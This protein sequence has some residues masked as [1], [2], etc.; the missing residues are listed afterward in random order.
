MVLWVGSGTARMGSRMA[1]ETEQDRSAR[2]RALEDTYIE[3]GWSCKCN[4]CNIVRQTLYEMQILYGSVDEWKNQDNR[5]S[6]L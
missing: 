1:E 2:C 4:T 3:H 5:E 6:I